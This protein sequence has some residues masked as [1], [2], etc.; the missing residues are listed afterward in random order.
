MLLFGKD[1]PSQSEIWEER[2]K[3]QQSRKEQESERATY[4]LNAEALEGSVHE[5]HLSLDV[6]GGREG[7]ASSNGSLVLHP[8][9]RAVVP[10]VPR[11]GHVGHVTRWHVTLPRM[12]RTG[13][14]SHQN[15]GGELRGTHVKELGDAVGRVVLHRVQLSHGLQVPLEDAE[16]VDALS[17]VLVHLGVVLLENFEEKR[18]VGVLD[19]PCCCPGLGPDGESGSQLES[20]DHHR[21]SASQSPRL[22]HRRHRR[23]RRVNCACR[24]HAMRRWYTSERISVGPQ[25]LEHSEGPWLR[26]LDREVYT[27]LVSSHLG[28]R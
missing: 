12:C 17:L 23:D 2:E 7:P 21:H 14:G 26:R 3:S 11:V 27:V 15:L 25:A 4:L 10:P 9:H 13:L 24:A 22:C 6:S 28:C 5:R 20:Q 8:R 18:R 19:W 1:P 16:T